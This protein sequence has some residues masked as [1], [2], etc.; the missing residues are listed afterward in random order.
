M[1]HQNRPRLRLAASEADLRAAKRLRYRVFY[2]EM[3]ARADAET[4]QLRLDQDRY[5]ANCDHLLVIADGGAAIPDGTALEDGLLI[6]TYRLLRGDIAAKHG[7]FYSESEFDLAALLRRKPDLRLLEVG[8]SCVAQEWRGQQVAELLWQGIW[9]YVRRHNLNAMTGCASLPGTDPARLAEEL[10]F[11]AYHARAPEDWRVSALPHR[12]LTMNVMPAEKINA[13]TV[14]RRLPTLIKGYLRLG[15]YV[16]DGA[17]IDQQFNTTD[18]L[19]MLPVAN[20]SPKYFGYFG[21][22][23]EIS[24]RRDGRQV[25]DIVGG[26]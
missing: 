15:C 13:R 10:S 24:E 14:L 4:A 12:R 18:V 5:D 1:D 25:Q 16:G 3:G 23:R 8:R 7:G 21:A 26:S 19:I 20:I 6:G 2:E 22:P 11:L 17:V 9:D